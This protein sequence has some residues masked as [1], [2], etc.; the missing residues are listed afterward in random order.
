MTL[1]T[2]CYASVFYSFTDN[3]KLIYFIFNSSYV[4]MHFLVTLSYPW[5]FKSIFGKW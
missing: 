1:Y 5:S 3:L 2:Q 4:S